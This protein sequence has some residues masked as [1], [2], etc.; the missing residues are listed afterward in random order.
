MIRKNYVFYSLPT[1]YCIK[2]STVHIG[3]VLLFILFLII[4][5]GNRR[6]NIGLMRINILIEIS[7]SRLYIII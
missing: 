4:G 2:K 6:T 5:I 1:G 3:I 7:L